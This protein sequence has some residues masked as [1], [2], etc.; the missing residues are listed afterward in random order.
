M[1]DPCIEIIRLLLLALAQYD[2]VVQTSPA[3]FAGKGRSAIAWEYC[4]RALAVAVINVPELREIMK[5]DLYAIVLAR[6]LDD[7]CVQ[8]ETAA[9]DMIRFLT[10]LDR[11]TCVWLETPLLDRPENNLSGPELERMV[12][13]IFGGGGG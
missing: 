1:T 4:K 3:W 8:T 11:Q 7:V 13:R 12:N 6:W 5:A 9:D 2:M 10:E